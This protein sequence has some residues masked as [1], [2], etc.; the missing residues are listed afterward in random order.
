M[1]GVA[2]RGPG[3]GAGGGRALIAGV[4]VGASLLFRSGLGLGPVL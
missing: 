2:E 4:Y 1:E 3:A